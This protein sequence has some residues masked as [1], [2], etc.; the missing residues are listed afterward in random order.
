MPS[1][2]SLR[3]FLLLAVLAALYFLQE[4]GSLPVRPAREAQPVSGTGARD[5]VDPVLEAFRAGH[6]DLIVEGRGVV[7]KVLRDDTKG[8]RHQRF[9]LRLDSGHTVLIS[10]NI[11]LA[12]RIPAL[13]RGDEVQFKGEYEWNDRG[14]VVHWTHRDPQGRHPHGFLVHGTRKYE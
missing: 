6:S 1:L 7:E 8:S 13:R 10:H 2:R 3:P 12:P 9:V 4:P 5:V 11:D 14:G